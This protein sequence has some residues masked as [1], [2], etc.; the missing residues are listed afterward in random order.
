MIN[1]LSIEEKVKIINNRINNLNLS[2]NDAI[3][4]LKK[5]QSQ[6]SPNLDFISIYNQYLSD[7][8][9]KISRLNEELDLLT[10]NQ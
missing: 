10:Q 5:E 9:L 3:D 2:M 4:C 8:K 6:E 7:S 1:S